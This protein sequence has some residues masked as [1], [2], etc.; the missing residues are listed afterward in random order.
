MIELLHP[1]DLCISHE[2]FQIVV[3]VTGLRKSDTA[4][5]LT[6]SQ[7]VLIGVGIMALTKTDYVCRA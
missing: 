1:G 7:Q 6:V 4:H 5:F 3:A 2:R